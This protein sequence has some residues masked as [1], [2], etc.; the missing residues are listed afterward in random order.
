M[1]LIRTTH[2]AAPVPKAPSE[3]MTNDRTPVWLLIGPVLFLI[4]IGISWLSIL[5]FQHD[6][7]PIDQIRI[8]GVM[9][10]L[11]LGYGIT[12]LAAL[13]IKHK[14]IPYLITVLL[15]GYFMILAVGN[16]YVYDET[17]VLSIVDRAV[18][19]Q[20]HIYGGAILDPEGLLLSLIHI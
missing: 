11:A 19:G 12:A 18:L 15:I 7:F 14:Y 1:T 10:R 5:C 13:L 3:K 8:L 20:A 2:K 17:N 16:G 9:Q 4:G 6:P